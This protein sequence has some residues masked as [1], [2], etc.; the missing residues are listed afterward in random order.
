M[1]ER[2]KILKMLE[3]GII[4]AQEAEELFKT[5]AN[6]SKK[7]VIEG[8]ILEEDSEEQK[9][10]NEKVKEKL[11]KALEK[12][13]KALKKIEAAE[14]RAS[15][16]IVDGVNSNKVQEEL[17]KAKEE[18]KKAIVDIEERLKRIGDKTVKENFK[19]FGTRME[20]LGEKIKGWF[21]KDE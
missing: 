21:V 13:R 16:K 15:K 5:M 12:M 3:E 14:L 4:T 20:N 9:N 10:C 19:D 6:Q 11:S 18:I 7:E 8:V 1:E 17:K 2:M